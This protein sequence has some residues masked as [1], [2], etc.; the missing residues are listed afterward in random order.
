MNSYNDVPTK[1]VVTV[2]EMARMCG[3]SR[4]RF[5]QLVRAGVFP[6]PVYA[7]T[8][9]RAFYIEPLQQ[10]CLQV[11]QT[12]HGVNNE[13]VFFYARGAQAPARPKRTSTKAEKKTRIGESRASNRDTTIFLGVLGLGLTVTPEQVWAVIDAEYPSGIAQS[14]EAEVIRRVFLT[15][16]RQLSADSVRR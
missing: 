6:P 8:T 10:V 16:K 13:P 3:L 11:R 5:Y 7:L 12:H 2:T 1:A 14:T 15:I 4:S 9:R